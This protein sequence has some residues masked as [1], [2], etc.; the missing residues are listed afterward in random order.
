MN[1]LPYYK[2]YP[3]DFFEGTIGM[4]FELKCAYRVVLDL[5]YMQGGRLPDDPRYI[6]GLLGCS[7]RKWFSLRDKLVKIGKLIPLDGFLTNERADDE[8]QLLRQ[9]SER[10]SLNAKQKPAKPPRRDEPRDEKLK[11]AKH[12]PDARLDATEAIKKYN[13]AAADAGWPQVQK[14]TKR[15]L[16]ACRA[17]LVDADGIDGWTAALGKA[18]KS[19]FLCGRTA[20]PWSGFG[21][22]WMASESNFNKIMEGNYDNRPHNPAPTNRTPAKSGD[23]VLDQI[24]RAAGIG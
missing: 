14:L 2:A 15:R 13:E 23:R 24:A 8:L 20:D 7:P 22:D 4:P 9:Y 11:P 6:S 18:A 19:D 16:S 3:R 1:G 5:I 17:R 21:F 12:D 10:Q